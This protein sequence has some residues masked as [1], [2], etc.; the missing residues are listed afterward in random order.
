MQGEG[1][2]SAGEMLYHNESISILGKIYISIVVNVAKDLLTS[3]DM[4][5]L[6]VDEGGL[7]RRPFRISLCPGQTF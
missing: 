1:G 6:G 4:Y 2:Y 7:S 3:M 5:V